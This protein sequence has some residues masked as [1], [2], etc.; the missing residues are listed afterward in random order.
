MENNEVVDFDNSLYSSV[1]LRVPRCD[2]SSYVC[3]HSPLKL[4]G[5]GSVYRLPSLSNTRRLADFSSFL[6]FHPDEASNLVMMSAPDSN[7]QSSSSSTVNV[8]CACHAFTFSVVFPASSLPL[9]TT[10][11]LCS[12]CRLTSGTT[13]GVSTIDLSLAVS[14]TPSLPS[15]EISS[16]LTLFPSLIAYNTSVTQTRWFCGSCGAHCLVSVK[17]GG[18]R[19]WLLST[20]L[21][22]KSDGVIR[23]EGVKFVGDT[24]DGGIGVW[25][26]DVSDAGD[27]GAEKR[28]LKAWKGDEAEELETDKFSTTSKVSEN[29]NADKEGILRASCHCKAV[30][31]Y[32]TRPNLESLNAYSPFPDL[33]IPYNSGISAANPS[34]IPWFIRSNNTKY[35]AGTCT[36]PS[37]RQNLG[38]DI[39]TWA[40]IPRCNIFSSRTGKGL[41]YENLRR[42]EGG[43]LKRYESS[44]GVHREF[45]GGCGA[46]VF[47]HCDV[48]PGVVD[49][50]TGLLEGWGGVRC[51][52]WLEWWAERVSFREIATSK[53]LVD[54][55]EDGL[56]QWGKKKLVEKV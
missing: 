36:C 9:P 37:C 39:Q 25:L 35:L 42:E 29:D 13:G 16:A 31:F 50:S 4:L 40:F 14:I 55:L 19:G 38:F 21:L 44:E 18:R 27:D 46:N 24:G 51:E 41:D 12:S 7:Q 17:E 11:C 15:P 48:R 26:R 30:R 34:H 23:W 52:E 49:V 3:Q 20:G 56:R 1:E 32:I 5:K 53:T 28:Q 22:E 43:M 6:I 33:M 2:N 54:S 47:W 8:S 10:L 45:C